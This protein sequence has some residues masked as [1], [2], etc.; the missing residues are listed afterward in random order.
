MSSLL[1]S[2]C[3]INFDTYVNNIIRDWMYTVFDDMEV[4]DSISPPSERGSGRPTYRSTRYRD[5]LDDEE[6][7]SSSAIGAGRPPL[8]RGCLDLDDEEEA[9][10]AGESFLAK[11]RRE[12]ES[13]TLPEDLFKPKRSDEVSQMLL[14][15]IIF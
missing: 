6:M 4:D 9:P 2:K 15:I 8:R 1:T 14:I 13:S 5:Y 10:A 7:L 3:K 12:K 11:F